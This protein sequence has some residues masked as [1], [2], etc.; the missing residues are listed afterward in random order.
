MCAG[1][2]LVLFVIT[3]PPQY[4]RWAAAG[5]SALGVAVFVGVPG[6]LGTILGLFTS[7]GTDSSSASRVDSYGIAL[8]YLHSSPLFGRGLATFL[9]RYRIFDNEYL[10]LLVEIGI[11]GVA[12]LLI[13]LGTALVGNRCQRRSSDLGLSLLVRGL[14][15]GIAAGALSLALFDAFSF[16]M[17]PGLLLLVGIVGAADRLSQTPA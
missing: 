2:G 1:I 13:L 9:P 6:M 15:A 5:I 14:V 8:S 4:R 12:S 11:V 7:I 16:A 10:L 3:L 17:M